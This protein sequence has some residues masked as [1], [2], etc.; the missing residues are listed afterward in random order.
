MRLQEEAEAF[1]ARKL[2]MT[3]QARQLAAMQLMCGIDLASALEAGGAFKAGLVRRIERL[4]ERERLKGMRRHWSYDL[5][6]HIA[7]K[8]VLDQLRGS[9]PRQEGLPAK[10]RVETAI[11][12]PKQKRPHAAP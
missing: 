12:H 1:G 3:M 6:R 11:D 2:A 4:I 10:R 9:G 8:Q 5:N 7:L